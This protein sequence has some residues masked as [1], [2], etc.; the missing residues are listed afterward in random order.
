MVG[1]GST[2]SN[3]VH[4]TPAS[5][6]IFSIGF[7]APILW[8]TCVDSRAV[9]RLSAADDMRGRGCHMSKS[10]HWVYIAMMESFWEG[11]LEMDE[12]NLVSDN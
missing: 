8:S 11:N 7:V 9:S 2:L 12:Q 10:I 3:T 5:F 6:S 4:S 1:F